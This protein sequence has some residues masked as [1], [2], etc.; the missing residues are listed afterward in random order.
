[1]IEN[2]TQKQ[3]RP[4]LVIDGMNIMISSLF[5]NNTITTNGVC[6][7]GVVG[8]L[9][10]LNYYVNTFAPSKVLICWEQGGSSS[11]RSK[12]YEGYKKNRIKDSSTM[13]EIK[14]ER[15][16]DKWVQRSADNKNQQLEMF[17]DK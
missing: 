9:K 2:N 11:R 12:I 14:R 10:S 7:G 13:N 15:D 1:M 8:F 4:I 17:E 6:V 16:D 3:T 5:A